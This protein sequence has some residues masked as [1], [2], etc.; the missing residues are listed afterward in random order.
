MK[1]H[2]QAVPAPGL[3][4]STSRL[5]DLEMLQMQNRRC[6]THPDPD[7]AKLPNTDLTTMGFVIALICLKLSLQQCDTGM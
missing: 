7:P 2:C 6:W 3:R 4:A 5:K 1:V